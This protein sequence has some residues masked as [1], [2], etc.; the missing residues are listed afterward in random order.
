[1]IELGFVFFCSLTAL[2]TLR[3]V[4]KKVGLVDTPNARKQHD[5]DIPLVG[6]IAVF[7]TIAQFVY[8]NSFMVPH[9]NLFLT[10]IAILTVL[11]A[12]DDKFD[13]SFKV[14]LIAQILLAVAMMYFTEFKLNFIG[15]ILGT[16]TLEFGFLA[17]T[18]TILAVL[19]AINAFNM[20]DGIDGLLGG[21]SIVT[22]TSLALILASNGQTDL[23][24][25]CIGLVVALIPYVAFNMGWFGRTRKVFMGD[26]GSMM[27]GFTVIWLLLSASQ[28]KGEP[29]IRPVTGLWLIGLPL[30]DMSAVMYRRVKRG[31]SPFKPDRDHLHHICLGLGLG[32]YVTLIVICALTALSCAIGIFGEF[33]EIPEPIM[34][35]G[36]LICFLTYSRLL[37]TKLPERF[38]QNIVP[39]DSVIPNLK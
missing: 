2:F 11:G 25:F 36:F 19:G 39:N 7:V 5:G 22:F 6:G 9:A 33:L 8:T 10:S 24:Y 18:I 3:K 27:I 21:I 1:M 38:K 12:V 15:D 23:T 32:K 14:R 26:A 30:M 20:V 37:A 4:A 16:G 34:F 29:L 13:I 17:P 31:R 35:F 28:V